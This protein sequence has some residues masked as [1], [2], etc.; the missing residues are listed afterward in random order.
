MF[1]N[2]SFMEMMT[3]NKKCLKITPRVSRCSFDEDKSPTY[4]MIC[5]ADTT[6]REG[7]KQGRQGGQGRR[8]AP[9]I[10]SVY[11]QLA[12]IVY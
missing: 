5:T 1:L 9:A 8:E 3:Q 11:T 10:A 4:S 7:K 6:T 12:L 2:V